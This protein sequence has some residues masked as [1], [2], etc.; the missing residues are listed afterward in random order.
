MT[1]WQFFSY[2][3]EIVLETQNCCFHPCG[4]MFL[5]SVMEEYGSTSTL[6][7]LTVV[8]IPADS[9]DCSGCTSWDAV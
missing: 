3:F 8:W 4:Q 2:E 5:T 6:N 1:R 9:G 7:F